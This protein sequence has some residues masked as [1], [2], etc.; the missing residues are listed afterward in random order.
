MLRLSPFAG[1]AAVSP[2]GRMET[3]AGQPLTREEKVRIG[4][5]LAASAAWGGFG[6]YL[7]KHKWPVLGGFFMVSSGLSL[8]AATTVLA[9]NATTAGEMV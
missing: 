8:A 5:G 6:Y 2:S 9:L 3:S 4:I 7:A 1:L